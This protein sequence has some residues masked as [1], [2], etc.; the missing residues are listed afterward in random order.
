MKTF[1]I[2]LSDRRDRMM[3]F[4]SQKLEYERFDAVNGKKLTYEQ[5]KK[6]GYD[7]QSDWIDPI[8]STHLTSGEVGCFLSHYNLWKKCIELNV[9]LCIL[10][11]DAVVPDNLYDDL[12]DLLETDLVKEHDKVL[13]SLLKDASEPT[14]N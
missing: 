14:G 8:H 4:E 7:T 2:N 3:L 11:D 12:D 10:E 13:T 9:P 6:L 5:L 1:V